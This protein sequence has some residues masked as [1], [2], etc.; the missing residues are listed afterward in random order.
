MKKL[1]ITFCSFPDFAGNAKALYEYM[2]KRYKD[3]MNYTW[4]VYNESTVEILKEKG[5]K[6][7]LIGTDEFKKYVPKTNVFFTTHANLTGD[8]LKAKDSIYV[9]LWHGISPKKV[10]FMMN[11]LSQDDE[12]WYEHLSTVIDY[13]IVPSEFWQSVFAN[14]FYLKI[15]QI[16][17]IGYPKLDL[18]KN[19]K[20]KKNLSLVLDED[21]KKYEKIIFYA[22][23]FRKG[24]GR[25]NDSSFSNNVLNLKSYSEDELI[26]YLEDNN[27]LLCIKKHPSEKSNYLSDFINTPR[28]KVIN[29]LLDNHN[30]DIYDVLDASDVLLTDYSSLGIE[31]LY[32]N[33]PVIYI[34]TD[35]DA[36]NKNR[37][38]LFSNFD[39]WSCNSSTNNLTELKRLLN[40]YLKNSQINELFSKQKKIFFSSL[41]DGGC[42]NIC[43]FFFD[44][45]GMIKD[46]KIYDNECRKK[47]YWIKRIYDMNSQI[48]SL[49][50][51]I[52]RLE[53]DVEQRTNELNLI[54]NSKGWKIIEK[55]RKIIRR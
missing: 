20:A 25:N 49:N 17:P 13:I 3:K 22:P 15:N 4:I 34:N 2:V 53:K 21:V 32:L 26:K 33:K 31:Y 9:E 8:K 11:N 55:I 54:L 42:K 35:S 6:S 36:Y 19:K 48:I 46:K 10:G 30:F 18:L 38:L 23:T 24:C 43:E 45:N 52:G 41:K 51:T 28:I 44:E 47:Q 39:F 1:N 12:R 14:R 7:I 5:I 29:D 16:L 37:G 50:D 40:D 27:Y